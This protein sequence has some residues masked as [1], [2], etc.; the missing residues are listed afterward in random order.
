MT[1]P[2]YPPHP[3]YPAPAPAPAGQYAPYEQYGQM[4]GYPAPP[5]PPKKSK[6][7]WIIGIVAALIAVC[8][9]G[10]LMSGGERS[11]SPTTTAGAPAG[12]KQDKPDS[13][14]NDEQ[15][16]PDAK[17]DV[18][19]GMNQPVRDGKFEFVVTDVTSGLTTVG[20]NEF[21]RQ[22]AQGK[23][24]VV[25]VSVKNIGDKPQGFSL[26][27]QK[28]VDQQGR[29]HESDTSA[30]IALGDSGVPVWD[31][32]NP[33]NKVAVK[34]VFDIPARAVPTELELHDSLFSNGVK[35]SLK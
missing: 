34:L 21:L 12:D 28:L 14:A 17:K 23:F 16:T 31:S 33:G 20:E 10:A 2:N 15:G 6:A 7:P 22:K 13:R 32:I 24:T 8:G 35:V 25:T 5:P 29:E 3:H 4:P 19:A 11:N 1:T 27:G 9:L 30:Q 18:I 26:S